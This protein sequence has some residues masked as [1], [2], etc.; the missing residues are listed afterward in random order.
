MLYGKYCRLKKQSCFAVNTTEIIS[1]YIFMHTIF[2]TY[3][4]SDLYPATRHAV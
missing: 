2:S 1:E 4:V 3:A